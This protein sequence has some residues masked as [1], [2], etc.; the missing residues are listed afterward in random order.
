MALIFFRVGYNIKKAITE[1]FFY[2]DRDSQITAIENTFEKAKQSVSNS[3]NTHTKLFCQKGKKV[4]AK[5]HLELI[6]VI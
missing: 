2:K 5:I 3:F 6:N 1:D 4:V